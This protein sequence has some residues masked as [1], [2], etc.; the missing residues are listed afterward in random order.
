MPTIQIAAIMRAGAF[1]PNHIGNDAGILNAVAQQLRKRGCTVAVYTEEELGRGLVT[2]RII[3]NMCRERRSVEMLQRMQDDGALVINSGYGIENCVR[4][5]QARILIGSDLPYPESIVVNTDEGVKT[6]LSRR[7]FTQCWIKRGDDHARH[8]EDVSYVRQP[9]EAQEVIQ[10]YFLRGIRR[11]V[12]SRH[13]RGELVKFYGLGDD[14]FFHWFFPYDSDHEIYSV[15]QMKALEPE[16][17][18]L[19]LRAS[20]ELEVDIFGGECMLRPTGELVLIA[21]NDW[22]TFSPCRTQAAVA[23]AKMVLSRARE[24]VAATQPIIK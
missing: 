14:S 4:E 11:A 3:I 23:I 24:Y 20:H 1:S 19:C 18:R 10:E 22:P 2:E 13:V 7:G 17:R 6:L 5:R 12:I 15:E 16:L 9:Q 21:L 8:K